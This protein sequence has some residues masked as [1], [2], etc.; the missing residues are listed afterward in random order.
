MTKCYRARIYVS[1][2]HLSVLYTRFSAKC[3]NNECMTSFFS[4]NTGMKNKNEIYNLLLLLLLL[5]ESAQ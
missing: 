5:K 3:D 2:I 1:S 4:Q